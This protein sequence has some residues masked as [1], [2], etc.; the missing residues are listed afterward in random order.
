LH[1]A[2]VVKAKRIVA[3]IPTSDVE[4]ASAFYREILG[5][6]VLM[7]LGWIRT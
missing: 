1:A 3:N 2:F 7:D 5:L 4:K 6:E